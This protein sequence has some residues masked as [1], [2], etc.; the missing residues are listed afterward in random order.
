MT[1]KVSETE[2]GGWT[3]LHIGGELDLLTSATVRQSVHDVVAVGRH[4][5]VLD[6]SGVLFCDSSGV[7]VLIALRRL[8]RSCGGRLRLILPARGAEEGSHVNRVLAALGVRRLFEV[9]PDWDAA[10]DEDAEPLTA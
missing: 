5:V 6:L 2:R 10:V 4:D 8:M 3:V 1:L 9:Y 7:G